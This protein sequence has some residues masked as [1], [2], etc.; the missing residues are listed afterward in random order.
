MTSIRKESPAWTPVDS[1]PEPDTPSP[2][3]IEEVL[4]EIVSYLDRPTLHSCLQVSKIWYR[5][6]IRVLWAAVQWK[7]SSWAASFIPEFKRYGHYAVELQDNFN[8]DLDLIAKTCNSLRELRLTWTSAT[9]ITLQKVLQASPKI[10]SLYLFSCRYLTQDALG[11]IGQL[12]SLQRLEIKN[13]TQVNEQTIVALL[14]A[15]PL[16]DH[17]ALEDVRLDQ[18]MLNSLGATPLKLRTLSLTRSSPTGNLTRNLLRNSPQLREFSL[19]RN[20]HTAL[21]REDILPLRDMYKHLFSLNLESCKAITSEALLALFYTCPQLERVNVSGTMM[22]DVALNILAINCPKIFSLNI[23]W[24]S[25]ISDQGLSRFLHS[26]PGLRYLNIT[27]T[28]FY[29]A[30]IFQEPAWACVGL[31][32][33]IMNGMDMTRPHLSPQANHAL[34]F[35]QLGRLSKLQDLALGGPYMDLQLSAGLARLDGLVC[36]HSIRITQLQTVLAEDEIRWFV[37][38]WPTLRRAKFDNETLP[39]PWYRYFRRQ[40][41]HLVLG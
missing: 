20:L 11:I 26:Y 15:C 13:L 5:A 8:A 29:S 18:V 2:L 30:A 1:T 12:Q 33:L 7:S 14:Q 3:R 27:S 21:T 31:E 10:S 24:C 16:L 25:Q 9:D 39:R 22:D 6:S 35:L 40:R 41:P 17:L 32:T 19:A 4:F 37:T 28:S 36:L 23:S 38:A 34:M